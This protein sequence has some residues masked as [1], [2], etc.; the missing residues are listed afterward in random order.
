MSTKANGYLHESADVIVWI[1]S[2]MVVS[3]VL[4]LATHSPWLGYIL[5]S[6]PSEYLPQ[7]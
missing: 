2:R 3:L 1:V 7:E 6:S 4:F 5:Q